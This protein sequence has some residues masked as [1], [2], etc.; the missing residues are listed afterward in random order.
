M[1]TDP[2]GIRPLGVDEHMKY[3]NIVGELVKQL[4]NGGISKTET[5]A[6]MVDTYEFIQRSRR[7]KD[8]KK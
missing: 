5:P 8:K 7:N 2:K 6:G 1:I 3:F 4:A